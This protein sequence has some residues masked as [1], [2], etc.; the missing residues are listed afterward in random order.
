MLASLSTCLL[1]H[2]SSSVFHQTVMSMS[3]SSMHGRK[4]LLYYVTFEPQEIPKCVL[5]G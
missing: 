3:G 5:T 2:P 4:L 1:I